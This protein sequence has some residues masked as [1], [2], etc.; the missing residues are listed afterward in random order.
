MRVEEQRHEHRLRRSPTG[1]SMSTGIVVGDR[2]S[3]KAVTAGD[4]MYA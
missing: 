4:D 3:Q 1:C 2:F